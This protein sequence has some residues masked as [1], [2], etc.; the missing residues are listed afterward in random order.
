[1]DSQETEFFMPGG[2]LGDVV[3]RCR[4]DGSGLSFRLE[5]DNP[6]KHLARLRVGGLTSGSFTIKDER[7]VIGEF[8]VAAGG[9]AVIKLPMEVGLRPKR[10]TIVAHQ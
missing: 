8:S 1:M 2:R 10:F 5:S 3:V 6:E 9:A 4:D 7:S